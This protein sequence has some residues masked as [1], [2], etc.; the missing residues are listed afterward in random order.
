[1]AY[2][3]DDSSVE[4]LLEAININTRNPI[5]ELT[6][7]TILEVISGQLDQIN[8]TNTLLDGVSQQLGVLISYLG[9]VPHENSVF[10]HILAQTGAVDDEVRVSTP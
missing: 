3:F 1:M 7:I 5:S 10:G 8:N 9:Y 4:S 2:P 6:T